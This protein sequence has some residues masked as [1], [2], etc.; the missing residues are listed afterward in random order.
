MGRAESAVEVSARPHDAPDTYAVRGI[1]NVI[2]VRKSEIVAELM[3]YHT[4]DVGADISVLVLCFRYD[5]T[6]SNESAVIGGDDPAKNR[7]HVISADMVGPDV[8]GAVAVDVRFLTGT[9]MDDDELSE[10]PEI[11]I[12]VR[13]FDGVIYQ[14]NIP[15]DGIVVGP[16]IAH[17]MIQGVDLLRHVGVEDELTVRVFQVI[18][19]HPVE[20]RIEMIQIVVGIHGS[21]T[22]GGSHVI[23]LEL[24]P[25]TEK[26][27]LASRG[28]CA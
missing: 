23:D 12:V 6:L 9:R 25:D 27:V 3:T 8:V 22:G 24:D 28:P 26:T 4:G 21:V 17:L 18:R 1:V 5:A 10:L 15:F 7:P 19:R 11:H 2:K 20:D 16:V 13:L 14:V